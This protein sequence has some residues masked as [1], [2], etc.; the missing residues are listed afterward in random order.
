MHHF[1]GIYEFK[2]E[3][4][5]KWQIWV[6]ISKFLSHVTFKFDKWPWKTTGH[7]F[8]ATSSFVHHFVTTGEFKL[9][10]QFGNAQFV[11]KSMISWVM[12]PWNLTDDFENNRAPLLSHIK[13]CASFH[14]HM[15]IQTEV[16]IRK[17]LNWVLTS[18]TLTFDL[19]FLH[20]HH[21][22]HW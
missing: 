12:W 11:L 16:T 9:E 18:V 21:F 13:L 10:S 4:V 22:C 20:G 14:H 17:R 5:W 8:S 19:D 6:K 7:L 15:W 1:I 2:M 3:L